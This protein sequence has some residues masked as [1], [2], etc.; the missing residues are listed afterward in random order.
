MYSLLNKQVLLIVSIALIVLQVVA[1]TNVISSN[2]DTTAII[3][4]QSQDAAEAI[5]IANRTNLMNDNKWY[6]YGPIYYRVAKIFY[7]AN[8]KLAIKAN[9][10]AEEKIR[11]TLDFYLMFVSVLSV[12]GTSIFLSYYIFK[13]ISVSLIASIPIT[14]VLMSNENVIALVFWNHPDLLLTFFVVAFSLFSYRLLESRFNKIDLY[15]FSIFAALAFLTKT[16][17]IVIYAPFM[18]VFLLL[19]PQKFQLVLK[20]FLITVSTY[21]LLGF[22]QSFKVISVLKFLK[23]QT[24]YNVEPNFESIT[25]WLSNIADLLMPLLLILTVYSLLFTTQKKKNLEFNYFE[26]LLVTISPVVFLCLLSFNSKPTYY[27]IPVVLFLCCAYL[28]LLRHLLYK[29]SFNLEAISKYG[30]TL[31]PYFLVFYVIFSQ[32][33]ISDKFIT[34]TNQWVSEREGV[35]EMIS[36]VK[37]LDPNKSKYKTSYFP[38]KEDAIELNQNLISSHDNL[39]KVDF[40]LL[41]RRWYGRYLKLNPSAYDLSDQSLETWTRWSTFY[42]HFDGDTEYVYIEKYKF[43]LIFKL[44]EYKIYQKY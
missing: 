43:K 6:A 24:I 3:S 15:I 27:V 22:Y 14:Q 11:A 38:Y 8:S 18:F 19:R 39:S 34:F 20:S 1:F 29:S 5:E 42:H 2:V 37:K 32:C 33:L 36:F 44:N 30:K 25:L 23:K 40:L 4:S 10:T 12:I 31:I 28:F 16:F 35:S 26:V 7:Y 9:Y 21:F 41:S 17:F 13:E